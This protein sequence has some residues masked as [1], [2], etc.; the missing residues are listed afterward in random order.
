VVG[1]TILAVLVLFNVWFWTGISVAGTVNPPEP[2]L[3]VG[4][5]GESVI[6]LDDY[7]SGGRVFIGLAV[8]I[9][10]TVAPWMITDSVIGD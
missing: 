8:G 5:V 10:G 6:T 1:V 3:L 9:V 4:S 7:F 2:S